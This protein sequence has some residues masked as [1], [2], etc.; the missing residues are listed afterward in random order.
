M[1]IKK[2]IVVLPLHLVVLD[3]IFKLNLLSILKYLVILN[4]AGQV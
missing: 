2:G 4:L 1:F 3:L